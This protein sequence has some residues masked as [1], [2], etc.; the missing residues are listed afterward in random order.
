LRTRVTFIHTSTLYNLRGSEN[1]LLSFAEAIST[2]G[3]D[4]RIINFDYDKRFPSSSS[5]LRVR[6]DYIRNMTK[7]LDLVLL[8]GTRLRLPS[9]IT[10][11]RNRMSSFI[12]ESSRFFPINR[13]LLRAIFESNLIYFVQC[14][15]GAT[16]L[17]PILCLATVAGRRR[18]IVGIH[19][20]PKVGLLDSLILKFFAKIGTL[21][22]A[23]IVSKDIAGYIQT[24]YGCRV[25]YIPNFV[26]TL[27][28]TPEQKSI[29]F[30][31]IVLYVGALTEVK[32]ADLLP[33]IYHGLRK[34]SIPVT[35]WICTQ[36]GPLQQ[37]IQQLCESNNDSV[38]YLGFVKHSELVNLY[39]QAHT[40]LIPS[41]REQ[42][43]FVPIEAQACGTPVVAS[44][45]PGLRQ[46][47]VDG[48]T[49][50]LVYPPTPDEFVHKLSMIY[51]LLTEKT[52][53]YNRMCNSSVDYVNK[54]FG[55]EVIIN[56]TIRL[57]NSI[58]RGVA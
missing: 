36:G 13:R 1:W 30:G 11:R 24:V 7:N 14:Q 37:R 35:L 17:I 12:M 44:D 46:L 28:F 16:H 9:L 8:R 52:E 38:K 48:K 27:I 40:V 21:K 58:L 47:L 42:F 29:N 43:P 45:I 19:V 2:L 22:A 6:E 31:F 10:K 33:D 54:N 18:V 56:S 34:M 32:G 57:F 5:E 51:R 50:L 53:H 20:T 49:G 26:D 25:Y 55:R 41:K 4:V 39:T 23:H 15:R 3:I